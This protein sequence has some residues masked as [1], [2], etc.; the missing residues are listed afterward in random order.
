MARISVNIDEVKVMLRREGMYII[1]NRD[2]MEEALDVMT[3]FYRD[4]DLFI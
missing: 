4:D 2:E 1:K 3:E